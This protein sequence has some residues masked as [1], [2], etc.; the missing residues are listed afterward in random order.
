MPCPEFLVAGERRGGTTTL[1]HW[2]S[3]SPRVAMT[4]ASDSMYFL[5]GEL[6]G[7]EDTGVDVDAE[8]WER[9]HP[10]GDY[11]SRFDGLA[12]DRPRGEKSADVLYWRSSHGRLAHCAP[13]VRIIVSLRDPVTRAWSHYW[14]EVGKGRESAPFEDALERDI[15]GR[16]TSD[17]QRFHLS[18][19]RRGFYDESLETLYET[20][21]REHV[22]ALVLE[23]SRRDPQAAL[24]RIHAFLGVEPAVVSISQRQVNRNATS[25]RRPWVERLGCGG[26]ES[27]YQ[28]VVRS[29]TSRALRG[30]PTR[31]SRARELTTAAMWPFRRPAA[32][33]EM[34]AGT[35]RRLRELYAPHVEC[36]Q[37]VLG[38]D[39]PL[40]W[41]RS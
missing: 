16:H 28:S 14:N 39:D 17:W 20:F 12:S 7:V 25:V 6:K 5:E 11:S 35:E 21:P 26:V 29:V 4:S 18:Y 33:E 38:R 8:R 23:E 37:S 40:P 41:G 24:D 22:L 31:W 34:A 2:L 32:S 30:S 13:D 1:H 3:C 9:E 10:P 19:G 36:L 15:A 27:A